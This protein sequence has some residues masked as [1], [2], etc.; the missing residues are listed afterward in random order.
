MTTTLGNRPKNSPR[1]PVAGYILASIGVGVVGLVT[2]IL[3]TVSGIMNSFSDV[4]E[5]YDD[6][7]DTGIEVGPQPTPVDLDDA[8][9]TIVSFSDS[10]QTPTVAELN[11]QCEIIDPHGEAVATNTSAQQI[12]DADRARF[13]RDL[14][15]VESIGFTHFEA[16]SGTY[17]VSCEQFGLLSDETSY[18]MGSTA[19]QGVLIGLGSVIVAGGLFVLGVVNSSRNKKTQAENFSSSAGPRLA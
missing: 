4:S 17:T 2:A 7:F 18:T 15:D 6:I 16:R 13:G 5:S 10:P 9:Y 14:V 12:A 3:I 1:R 11:Q 8:K 19:M